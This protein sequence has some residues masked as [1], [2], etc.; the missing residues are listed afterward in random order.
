MKKYAADLKSLKDAAK[1][2]NT[3]LKGKKFLVGDNLTLADVI[4]AWSLTTAFQLCF[5]A[6]F[7][8][9][10]ADL[11]KWFEAFTNHPEVQKAAGSIK[12]C[13]VAIK[14]KGAPE[15]VEEKADDDFDDLFGEDD[16][17]DAEA[18]KKAGSAAKQ[19][20]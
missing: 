15:E 13:S 16:E 9:A 19:K 3:T 4:V 7:R 2:L 8:K 1:E 18:A 6:G 14:P 11:N 12:A 10:H 17:E 20:A 5:D